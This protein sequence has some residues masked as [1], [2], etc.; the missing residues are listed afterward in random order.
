M[1]NT[2]Q[3][4]RAIVATQQHF[5][6]LILNDL[7]DKANVAQFV[8][9]DPARRQR[10][11]RVCGYAPN[12]LFHGVEEALGILLANSPERRVNIRSF[13]PNDP[14]GHEFVY[15]L[16]AVGAA[17]SAVERLTGEGLY[18]I[19]NET[20]D[21]TDGGVSGVAHGDVIEFAPGSTPRV[22][23]T[24]DIVSTERQLGDRI[25]ELVYGFSTGI[26]GQQ[27][28]RIE[29]S[30][31]P[32]RRGYR[33]DHMIVW[34]MEASS[35]IHSHPVLMWPNAFSKLIGDK[36]FGLVVA[37]ALG[38]RVPRATNLCR[39][40]RPFTFG[41]PTGEEVVWLRTCPSVPEPGLFPTV[42]GWKDPF[43]LVA[44]VPGNEVIA[45]VL[46]QD[47]VPAQYS[48][49]VLTSLDGKM[50][51]EGVPG[52]GDD[53]MLGRSKPCALP[54]VVADAVGE[55]YATLVS[56]IGSIRAEWAFDGDSAWVLQVQPEAALSQDAVIVPGET[57]REMDFDVAGGLSGLREL[58]GLIQGGSVGIRLR[59]QVGMTSHIADVLRRHRIPSRIVPK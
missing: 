26:S 38:I 36:A 55:V 56:H 28:A 9:F 52:F 14:Q 25:L 30:L 39:R 40:I 2:E 13:H 47:E 42:R 17:Q 12:Y 43:E 21:V 22:V 3:A 32:I 7:A 20:V 16:Q 37:A 23:E 19:A 41:E 27:D 5:K 1:H 51:L 50:I 48:G 4:N 46:V 11:A 29:F 53:L 59:G 10:F 24:G 18:V 33:H 15:G 45:S 31:H 54:P 8:S 58:L 6:D 49:A 34:E 35:A 57:E 44:E